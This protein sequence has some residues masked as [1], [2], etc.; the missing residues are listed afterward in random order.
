MFAVGPVVTDVHTGRK[1]PLRAITVYP[2]WAKELVPI[3]G[4]PDDE[5][6][7]AGP[8]VLADVTV[9]ALVSLHVGAPPAFRL[10]ELADGQACLIGYDGVIRPEIKVQVT[11]S[12]NKLVD[13]LCGVAAWCDRNW[14]RNQ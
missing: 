1:H 7:G 9:H 6:E 10:C 8:N 4:L 11:A 3:E 13:C 2:T 5:S 12:P 14:G